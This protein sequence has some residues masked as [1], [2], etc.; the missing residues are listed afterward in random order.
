MWSP[1]GQGQEGTTASS[2]SSSS[3]TWT[4]RCATRRRVPLQDQTLAYGPGRPASSRS[5]GF[6]KPIPISEL[7]LLDRERCIQCTRST[8]F[9]TKW[10]ARHTSTSSAGGSGSRSTPSP[11][12]RYFVVQRDTVQIC[13]VGALPPPRTAS[14]PGPRT[15]TRSSRPARRARRVP[16]GGAVVIEPGDPPAGHRSRAGEPWL[17]VRQG[18]VRRDAVNSRTVWTSRSSQ[19]GD[20]GR[21]RPGTR[22]RRG[23]R[24]AAPG[25]RGREPERSAWWAAPG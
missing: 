22:P 14:R 16:G 25:L 1:V 18:P 8:R 24:G 5:S 21:R 3:T 6:E 11:G 10:P 4:A 12:S 23:G 17:A 13:P 20:P 7:V 2:S 15:S 9:A 19:G